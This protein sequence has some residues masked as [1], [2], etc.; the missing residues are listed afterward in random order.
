MKNCPAC[1]S[2]NLDNPP[3]SEPFGCMS[4]HRVVHPLEVKWM[5]EKIE[6]LE[7]DNARMADTIKRLR[8]AGVDSIKND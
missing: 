7:A 5:T 3:I 6:R 4:C 1:G 2:T 8:G